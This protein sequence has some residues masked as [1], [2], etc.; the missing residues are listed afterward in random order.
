MFDQ[1]KRISNGLKLRY[2]LRGHKTKIKQIVWSPDGKHIA[3][4]CN[5]TAIHIWNLESNKL[6]PKVIKQNFPVQAVTWSPDS[7]KKNIL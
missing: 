6:E 7:N 5:N 2:I 4:Y 1:N 3:S